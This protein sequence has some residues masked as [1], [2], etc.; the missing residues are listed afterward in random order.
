V[1]V[2]PGRAYRAHAGGL[3]LT[4]YESLEA[5]Q[6]GAEAPF[7]LVSLAHV[8][9]HLPRPVDY[10][11]TLRTGFLEPHGWLLVEVPNL[12]C[13]DSFELAHLVSFSAHTLRQTLARAGFEVVALEKHGR[14]RSA[15]LPL[16]LTV[17]A[18]PS[19]KQVV[20]IVPERGAA[21][22]RRLGLARRRLHSRLLPGRAWLPVE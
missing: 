2:E 15:V 21:L 3:G 5:L 8:L 19:G 10:L 14:P 6:A 4:V 20:R 11:R 13:H 7:D 22:K 12:Y 9:E 16:Y 17:L 1:G 18:R